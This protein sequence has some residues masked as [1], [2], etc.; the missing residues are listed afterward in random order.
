MNDKYVNIAGLIFSMTKANIFHSSF[1][2]PVKSITETQDFNTTEVLLLY[3][4]FHKLDKIG[5]NA[6]IGIR[7]FTTRKQKNQVTPSEDRTQASYEPLMI[8]SPTLSFLT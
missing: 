7:G 3:R 5:N 2:R 1:G 4:Y 6:N 8:P